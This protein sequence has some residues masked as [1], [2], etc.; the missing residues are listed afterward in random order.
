MYKEC[1]NQN[2]KYRGKKGLLKNI[3]NTELFKNFIDLA[4][5]V[6]AYDKKYINAIVI[7]EKSYGG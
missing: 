2:S 3:G 5:L 6:V 1:N 4:E 7:K